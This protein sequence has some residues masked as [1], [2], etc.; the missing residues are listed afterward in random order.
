VKPPILRDF[1]TEFETERLLIRAPQPGDGQLINE[2]IRESQASLMPWLPFADPLPTI[3]ESEEN[4]RRAYAKF[5]LREDLRLH[6]FDRQ[7]R[8]FLGSSG[9]HRM[10]WQIG[11]FE[12]GYWLRDSASG[13]GYM[14][15]AVRSTVDFADRYLGARRIEIRCDGRNLRSRKVA[16]R[17]GFVLEGMLRENAPDTAGQPSDTLIYAKLKQP[18]GTWGYPQ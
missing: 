8:R 3:D 17:C 6:V 14:T 11:R 9:L 16:E 18:D 4:V 7:T 2:A 10:N 12:I 15:E 1:P 13:Q 5:I